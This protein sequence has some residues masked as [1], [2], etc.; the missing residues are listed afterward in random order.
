MNFTHEFITNS[1]LEPWHLFEFFIFLTTPFS[2]PPI[3]PAQV[4]VA[5]NIS[6]PHTNK[7]TNFKRLSISN[8]YEY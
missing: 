7:T 6:T 1:R 4:K 8:S 3:T 2:Y 5:F